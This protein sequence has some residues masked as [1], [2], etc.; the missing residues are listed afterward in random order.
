VDPTATANRTGWTFGGGVE[1][2]FAPQWSVDLE[3]NCY[4]FGTQTIILTNAVPFTT[5]TTRIRDQMSA[6]T[7][8]VN[9]HF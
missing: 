4:D 8:G 1:W 3:S 7:V 9:Y 6:T 2:A 5:V